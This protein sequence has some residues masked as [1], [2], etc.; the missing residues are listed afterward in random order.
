[1]A[2]PQF[3]K[4][5]PLISNLIRPLEGHENPVL[6]S[7]SLLRWVFFLVVALSISFFSKREKMN[8]GLDIPDI[9]GIAKKTVIAPF[10]YDIFKSE[11]DLKKERQ[12]A[13]NSVYPVLEFDQDLTDRISLKLNKLEEDLSLISLPTSPDSVKVSIYKN[14]S[15]EISESTIDLLV[16]NRL[17]FLDIREK[18]EQILEKG[19]LGQLFVADESEAEHYCSIHKISEV[20][21]IID[22]SNEFSLIITTEDTVESVVKK[23]NLLLKEEILAAELD[24]LKKKYPSKMLSSV[25]EIMFVFITPNIFYDLSTTSQR[26]EKGA[27]AVLETKGIVVKDIEIVRSHQLVTPEIYEKLTSLQISQE[28]LRVPG[29]RLKT[30]FLRLGRIL[31][32]LMVLFWTA[33][34]LYLFRSKIYRNLRLYTS[35]FGLI[36]FQ[37]LVNTLSLNLVTRIFAGLDAPEYL[38]EESLIPITITPMLI[39]ILFDFELGS[40]ISIILAFLQGIFFGFEN[41]YLITSLFTSLI[42]AYSVK[43]LKYRFHFVVSVGFI[44]GASFL[45]I[46]IID[47]FKLRFDL[48]S[49]LYNSCLSLIHA[50]LAPALVMILLPLIERL[51]NMVTNITLMELADMNRSLLKQLSIEAPGTSHHSHIMANLAERAA[52]EIGA[53]PLLARVGAYYHDIGKLAKSDYF[54]ENQPQGKNIH[55]ELLPSQSVEIIAAHVKEGVELAK[56]NNLPQA[57]IDFITQH[58]GTSLISFFY[59]KASQLDQNAI[60]NKDLFRYPGPKPQSK[61]TAIVMLADSLE[62]ASRTLKDPSLDHLKGLIQKIIDEKVNDNQFEECDLTFKDLHGIAHGFLPIL[63]GIFHS[64]IEYPTKPLTEDNL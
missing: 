6:F 42:A 21:F 46:I 7:Q 8:I 52:A 43:D 55:S 22:K 25:Y 17:L 14:W 13:R 12:Q 29:E 37:V 1:M 40:M 54:I 30:V 38:L 39:T 19:V 34:Y 57:L 61:E 31:L 53:N 47:L 9:G 41:I 24:K 20:P 32:I 3:K 18:I 48:N 5:I 11:Q 64:R 44:L 2:L 51:L 49:I 28:R 15:K 35:I 4:K 63:R 10:T 27:E 16:K 62:A 36:L 60:V 26:R 50:L 45:S 33:G 58:H 56:K 23:S 59:E